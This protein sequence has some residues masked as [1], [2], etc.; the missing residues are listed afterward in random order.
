MARPLLPLLVASLC[1][2]AAPNAL[3]DDEDVLPGPEVGAW[4]ASASERA[5][6]DASGGDTGG[7]DSGGGVGD[8]GSGLSDTAEPPLATLRVERVDAS[9]IACDHRGITAPCGELGVGSAVWSDSVRVMRVTYVLRPDDS[10]ATC[11]WDSA[12][13]LA[14]VGPDAGTV[15]AGVTLADGTPVDGTETSSVFPAASR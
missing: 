13:T 7:G 9:T 8:T 3:S 1:A 10:D 2:C 15:V 4:S 5:L 14:G 6:G 11:I 12:Y